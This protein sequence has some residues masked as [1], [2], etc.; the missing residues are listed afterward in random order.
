MALEQA[1]KKL[2]DRGGAVTTLDE[3]VRRHLLQIEERFG[4]Q[5][6]ELTHDVLTEAIAK[7]RTERRQ[8]EALAA[9]AGREAALRE[10]LRRQRRRMWPARCPSSRSSPWSRP[11][12]SMAGAKSAKPPGSVTGPFSRKLWP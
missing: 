9:A 5:G 11:W 6:I 10:T 3:L 12:R 7:S 8:K 4:V 1:R 2:Q